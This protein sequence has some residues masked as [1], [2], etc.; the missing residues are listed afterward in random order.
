[1]KKTTK[2]RTLMADVLFGLIAGLVAV[3]VGS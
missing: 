1:M 2:R 3:L